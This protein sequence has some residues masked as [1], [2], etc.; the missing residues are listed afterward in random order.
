MTIGDLR[1]C[2]HEGTSDR[3]EAS[4]RGGTSEAGT[5]GSRIRRRTIGC[6]RSVKRGKERGSTS[7]HAL[8]RFR[9]SGRRG[10]SW[11]RWRPATQGC[12]NHCIRTKLYLHDRSRRSVVVVVVAPVGSCDAAGCIFLVGCTALPDPEVPF[13]QLLRRT[14]IVVSTFRMRTVGVLTGVKSTSCRPARRIVVLFEALLA[15]SAERHREDRKFGNN[16]FRDDWISALR[17]PDCGES[18]RRDSGA[19]SRALQSKNMAL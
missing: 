13:R 1:G 18:T 5:G 4:R 15:P 19:R 10:R 6:H 3:S 12:C 17:T 11:F 2:R 16:S 7:H 9:R 8:C 14:P